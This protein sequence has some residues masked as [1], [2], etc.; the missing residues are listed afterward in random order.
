[1]MSLPMTKPT[2]MSLVPPSENSSEDDV[3][4]IES[5]LRR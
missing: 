3:E 2:K 4:S 1:M 5:E